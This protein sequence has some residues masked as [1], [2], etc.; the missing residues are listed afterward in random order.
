MLSAT[1]RNQIQSIITSSS[2]KKIFNKNSSYD[3]VKDSRF[4]RAFLQTIT[5]GIEEKLDKIDLKIIQNSVVD[6]M[7]YKQQQSKL[8]NQK[9]MQMMRKRQK[10]PS[11]SMQDEI[12]KIINEN[13]ICVISGETGCGKTTQVAQFILDDYINNM[14]GSMCRVV[15]T[16]P[17][18][19]S[20][21]SVAERVAEERA[22]N[23]GNSVGF[24]IRL[25]K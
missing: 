22:E 19:I 7:L 13:Q 10:L 24:H 18:R 1:K 9:Y 5:E 6:E 2:F 21:I 3:H 14:K 20:A 23:I 12:L 25:E 11:Y 16:Q 8:E 4:K 17:R 15:C